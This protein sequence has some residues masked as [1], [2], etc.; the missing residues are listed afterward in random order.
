MKSIDKKQNLQRKLESIWPNKPV[1][2]QI[3][4]LA[5]RRA[6]ASGYL[7]FKTTIKK[8]GFGDKII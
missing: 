7:G 1:V 6:R 8:A 3:M 5:V 4:N 2:N